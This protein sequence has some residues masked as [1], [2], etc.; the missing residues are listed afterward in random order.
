[1]PTAKVLIA[2]AKDEQAL[3]EKLAEPIRAAGYQVAHEGTV[4]VGESLVE[5][6]SRQLNEGGAVVLCGTARAVGSKWVRKMVNTAHSNPGVRVLIMQME[7]EAD[8]EAVSFDGAIACYWQDAAKAEQDLIAALRHYFPPESEHG[9]NLRV[10]DLES[11]YRELALE[12]CDIIDLANLPEGDRHHLVTRELKL[13]RLYVSLRM[14]VE[15]SADKNVDDEYR[16]QALEKR[17]AP[18]WSSDEKADQADTQKVSAGERL[19]TARRLVVLGDP[20]AGKSTLLRWLATAWLLRLKNDPD[21]RE[22]PDIATLPQQEWL[23]ILVRCRDLPADATL[24]DMLLHSLR[25]AELDANACDALHQL[26]RDRLEKGQALL[27]VDGLDEIAEPS[28]RARFSRQLEQIFRACP[29]APIVVTSRI[30]GY[31]EMGYRIRS[32][33]EHLSIANLSKEDKDDF[34]RRWCALTEILPE[35]GEAAAKELIHDIHSSD[36]IE[37]LTGNPMLLTTMALI[38]RK[39]GQLP[40]RRVDLYEKAVEVLLNWRSEVDAPLDHREALPQLEYLAYAMCERGAQRLHEDDILA[41]L[42]RMREEYP[43]IHPLK[44]HCPEDFLSLLER[45]TGLLIQSGHTRHD[46][47]SVPVYEFRHLTFQEYLAGLALVQGHYPGRDKN[48]SLADCVAPLAGQVEQAAFSEFGDKET[49]VTEN[50]REALRLCLTACNDDDVDAALCAILHPLADEQETVRPR[51]VMAALCLADE[52]NVSDELAREVLRRLAGQVGEEDGWESINTSLGAAALELAAS[53]WRE[54]LQ[55]A[56]LGEFFRRQPEQREPP[57]NLYADVMELSAPEQEIEF[58]QWLGAR[59]KYLRN[60][61]EQEAAGSALVIMALA[62]REKNCVTPAI[63][64][65]LLEQLHGSPAMCHASVWALYWMNDEQ[66][67]EHSWHP[68]PEELEHLLT[69]IANPGCDSQAVYWLSRILGREGVVQAVDALLLHL[70]SPVAGT[71]IGV[72]QA[73]GQ[74]G[75]A[76][77]FE[78]LLARLEDEDG[79]VQLAAAQ[80]LIKIGDARGIDAL[81]SCLRNK[82][83]GLRRAALGGLA[84]TCNKPIERKLLGEYLGEFPVFLD[85]QAPISESR[86]AEAAKKLRKPAA[87]IRQRYEV[88]AARFGLILAWQDG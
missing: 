6:V 48:K 78:S 68:T 29:D 85:P 63:L 18:V 73:L 64:A 1:M 61:T 35:R 60:G 4:L 37:R 22:L 76:R 39:I 43:R 50:W 15:I 80:A 8:T 77:A 69:V 79:R 42:R 41:L 70:S 47:H 40:Q 16:L 72:V 74:I 5:T 82:N 26:L 34:A 55:D 10:H 27:L 7:E 17:R 9:E 53:R 23:P 75:D 38:K 65:S 33:V 71:R 11:R 66:H 31:R 58:S 13:R 56:L 51:A 21:W 28:A 44:K 30:V 88:L 3:A 52:P 12:A 45:R 25:K 57:G 84:Q 19:A 59:A 49:A 67:E 2:H 14:N 24:D 20:G 36:R 87:E 86:I 83:E 62:F 32:G 81:K 46:G 54:A